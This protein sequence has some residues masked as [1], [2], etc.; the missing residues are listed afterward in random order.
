MIID[1]R[2]LTVK[3]WCDYMV[4]ELYQFG[5]IP[6]LQRERA[7]PQWAM[8]VIQLPGIAKFSPPDPRGFST[9]L[10]WAERFNQTVII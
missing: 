1:P 8:A 5:T 6:T 9:W 10:E 2:G 3:E 4:D 7:W